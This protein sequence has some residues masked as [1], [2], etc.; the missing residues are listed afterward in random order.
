MLVNLNPSNSALN[1]AEDI[2][3]AKTPTTVS[4]T[5]ALTVAL[6]A[7][8]SRACYSIYNAGPPT[9]YLREGSTVSSTL[10]EVLI[11][12]GFYYKEEFPSARYTGQV[13]VITA[14]G[15]ASLQVS[16]GLL[17]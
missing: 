7:N 16:E 3:G 9:V 4:V 1:I 15:T 2:R 10:Y 5:N 6:A 8:T 12:A 14:S 17:T 11:P 13:S